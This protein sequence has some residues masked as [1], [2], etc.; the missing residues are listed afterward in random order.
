MY[1]LEQWCEKIRTSASL[2]SAKIIKVERYQQKTTLRH[3]FL[4]FQLQRPNQTNDI[5]LR[6]DRRAEAGFN[7]IKFIM[8][9]GVTPSNDTVRVAKQVAMWDD[10]NCNSRPF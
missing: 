9:S 4:V 6:L 3:R 1:T 5:F 2:S 10:A 8:K 7:P